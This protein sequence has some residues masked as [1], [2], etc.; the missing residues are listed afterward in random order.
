MALPGGILGVLLLPFFFGEAKAGVGG[1][2]DGAKQGQ[3]KEFAHHGSTL[4]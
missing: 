1:A 4:G 2:E 3:D